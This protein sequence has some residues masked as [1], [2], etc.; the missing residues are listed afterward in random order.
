MKKLIAIVGPTASG[1]SGVAKFV[2]DS[3][4]NIEAISIDSRQ[5]FKGLDIGTG[6]DKTFFQHLIDI[7][8]PGESIS[9]VE[10][11]KTALKT[12]KEIYSRNKT[13][14]LVGG[15]NYYMDSIIYKRKF[16][17]VENDKKLSN[18]L[19]NKTAD[20]LF[21]ILQT[22]DPKRAEYIDVKNKRRLVRA[23]EINMLTS[24]NTIEKE[25]VLNKNYRFKTMILGV[26]VEREKL[27]K[28]INKRVEE[29]INEGMV[30]E[31]RDLISK[32]VPKSWLKKLGL[33]YQII[34]EYLEAKCTKEEM[35]QILK[36]RIHAFA[37]RQLTWLRS[38]KDIVWIR[39]KKEALKQVQGFVL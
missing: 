15:S 10:F 34:T 3:L 31:V 35:I 25:K 2:V 11:Q 24:K 29:R 4:P 14:I 27:Y 30:K 36:Y 32:K 19:N 26:E 12:V 5:V 9:V 8:N 33:E 20:E 7:K 18:E 22:L 37:R 23:L 16:P 1:K 13:P 6:K 38:N 21:E 17:K 39:D 28:N